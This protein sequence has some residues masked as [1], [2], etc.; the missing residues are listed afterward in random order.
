MLFKDVIL[1]FFLR[2]IASNLLCE[3]SNYLILFSIILKH[4]IMS[5]SYLL[6]S[7]SSHLMPTFTLYIIKF[8]F[9]T[10]HLT[11]KKLKFSKLMMVSIKGSFW[12]EM[13]T[14]MFF[15]IFLKCAEFEYVHDSIR[16]YF[17]NFFSF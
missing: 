1:L 15:N 13:L 9:L 2:I 6:F 11:I 8:F 4:N 17:S 12:S 10:T 14:F 3:N 7:R 16:F 5:N